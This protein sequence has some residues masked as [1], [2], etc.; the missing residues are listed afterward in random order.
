[1]P[2]RR[3]PLPIQRGVWI[4]WP[5]HHRRI[6]PTPSLP[7]LP[8][9]FHPNSTNAPTFRGQRQHWRR[10]HRLLEGQI[11]PLISPPRRGAARLPFRFP[12]S[13]KDLHA[14]PG[15]GPQLGP[16]PASS[17]Q[18]PQLLR[19]RL[20]RDGPRYATEAAGSPF[21]HRGRGR[22]AGGGDAR[23]PV[24]ARRSSVGSGD[25]VRRAAFGAGWHATPDTRARQHVDGPC[26]ASRAVA[27]P[28]TAGGGCGGDG[29]GVRAAGSGGI[30]AAGIGR[31]GT[32]AGMGS[33][34]GAEA[35]HG[36]WALR[37]VRDQ[38]G[39]AASCVPES[40][41]LHR[42]RFLSAFSNASVIQFRN[43]WEVGASRAFR[44]Q[45]WGGL[46]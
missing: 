8:H 2:L 23:P 45:A 41:P 1:M 6:K 43:W 28:A 33:G 46:S 4:L 25:V 12:S 20:R 39:R 42:V 13:G 17:G 38:V 21:D 44:D 5:V 24:A 26:C 32:G 36:S 15:L 30:D 11:R 10:L 22:G 37:R 14:G 27:V 34:A 31:S 29:V 9:H 19:R 18:A 40:S 7:L 16:G 35:L 3:P